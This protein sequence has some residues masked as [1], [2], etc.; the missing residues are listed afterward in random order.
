MYGAP[1]WASPDE[2][3]P[4]GA[5]ATT[6]TDARWLVQLDTWSATSPNTGTTYTDEKSLTVLS[7]GEAVFEVSGTARDLDAWL[8][9]R[10]TLADIT[11]EGDCAAFEEMIRTGVQ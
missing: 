2:T 5:I 4:I 11:R 6:D 8:W 3:G 1:G 9:N 10:P 7:S